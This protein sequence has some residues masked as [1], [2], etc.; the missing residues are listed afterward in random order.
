MSL[1][2]LE[3][4]FISFILVLPFLYETSQAFRYYFKFFLYYGIIMANSIILIPFM[5]FQ[6]GNVKNFL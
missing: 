1:C 6:P 3:I 4:I 2:C 5:L